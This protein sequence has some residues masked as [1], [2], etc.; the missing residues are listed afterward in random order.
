MTG[1][2]NLK[3]HLIE[4]LWVGLDSVS[5]K[6]AQMSVMEAPWRHVNQALAPLATHTISAQVM[7]LC[8]LDV[9]L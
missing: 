4:S 1:I 3:S 9:Q 6:H 5:V 8:M 7:G 2:V